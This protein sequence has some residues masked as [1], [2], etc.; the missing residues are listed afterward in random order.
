MSCLD[1][2]WCN[3]CGWLRPPVY[4][5]SSHCWGDYTPSLHPSQVIHRLRFRL[6]A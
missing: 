5:G 1:Y 4:Y 3:V 6:E 2:A